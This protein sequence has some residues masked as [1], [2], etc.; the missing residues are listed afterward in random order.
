VTPTAT[1][2][3]EPGVHAVRPSHPQETR[4]ACVEN[5]WTDTGEAADSKKRLLALEKACLVIPGW[6][7]RNGLSSRQGIEAEPV[8]GMATGTPVAATPLL[9]PSLETRDARRCAPFSGRSSMGTCAATGAALS[10]SVPAAHQS[11]LASQQS[12]SQQSVSRSLPGSVSVHAAHYNARD[13][14]MTRTQSPMFAARIRRLGAAAPATELFSSPS[15]P[16]LLSP[17]LPRPDCLSGQFAGASSATITPITPGR[18][19][20]QQVGC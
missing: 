11:G 18:S 10:S 12:L 19:L 3:S 20:H 6:A 15:S 8:A 14:P 13:S 17:R 9:H 1:L 5:S 16:R 4:P 2:A 7:S